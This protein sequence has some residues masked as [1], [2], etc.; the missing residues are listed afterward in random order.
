MTRAEEIAKQEEWIK[1]HPSYKKPRRVV[2][3]KSSQSNKKI[4]PSKK[5]R[6]KNINKEY[7]KALRRNKRGLIT[8]ITRS[9]Q[10]FKDL[11]NALEIEYNFQRIFTVGK[12]GYIVDF[13]LTD[14]L[15]VIEIDG[16]NH[17]EKEQDTKDGERTDNLLKLEKIKHIIRFDN[18]E[19]LYMSI[20]NLK[21]IL[22]LKIC[23][24]IEDLL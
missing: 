22:G 16:S 6:Q 7:R 9:E 20:N 8:N 19:V 1:K 14:Y 21:R 13:Y 5:H 17:N 15:T 23:P 10:T 12:K 2:F 4:K 18:D 3:Y 24:F 11:L